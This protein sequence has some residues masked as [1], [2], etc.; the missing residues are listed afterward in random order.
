M[1]SG[2]IAVPDV[3]DEMQEVG[4]RAER[5][6]RREQTVAEAEARKLHL[7]TR[8]VTDLV[9]EAMQQ[10]HRVRFSWP[11]GEAVGVPSAAVGD[12]VVIQTERGARALNTAALSAVEVTEK[13]ASRGSPGDRT[14]ESFVAWIRMVEGRDA[15]VDMRGG[16]W[17]EGT[18]LATASDHILLRGRHGDEIAVA[19]S[20]IAAI[21][22]AGDPVF[23]V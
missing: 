16:R 17:Y 7:A 19:R 3:W 9:W 20:Q 8:S 1:T 2:V 12:L 14:V 4:E 10:G 13:K 21:S 22:V 15:R 18:V 6:A 11:G 5:D 23:P